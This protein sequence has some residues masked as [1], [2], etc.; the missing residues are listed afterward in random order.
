LVGG[1]VTPLVTRL[2]LAGLRGSASAGS[3][4]LW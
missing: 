3:D 1:I 4:R 2:H